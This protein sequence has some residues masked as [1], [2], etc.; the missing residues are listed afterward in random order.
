MYLTAIQRTIRQIPEPAFFKVLVI[1]LLLTALALLAATV[2]A[3]YVSPLVYESDW[4]WLNT[5]IQWAVQLAAVWLSFILFV[6][7]SAVFVSIFLDSVVDAVEARFYPHRLA[8]PPL[9]LVKAGWL[10][11]RLGAVVLVAN[12]AALP[13]YLLT[14]WIPFVAVAIFYGINAYLLGWG[15]YDLIATRHMETRDA[16]RHR[17]TIRTELLLTGLLITLLFSIPVINLAA[18]ILGAAFF[19]HI[20]HATLGPPGPGEA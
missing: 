4:N 10:G 14:F 2:A 8:G 15:F 1:G 16:A 5:L 7:L 19:V 13:L 17:R 18:P 6:P 12:V 11:L 9:G 3:G 20:F